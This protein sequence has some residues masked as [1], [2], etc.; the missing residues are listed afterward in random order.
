MHL[1]CEV[2]DLD[3]GERHVLS[4]GGRKAQYQPGETFR[5]FLDPVGY[6]F[7]LIMKSD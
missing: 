4:M 3:E 7:C 2:D 5:V 1:D 6:P